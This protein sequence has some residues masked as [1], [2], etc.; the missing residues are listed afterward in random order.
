MDSL[1]SV[2]GNNDRDILNYALEHDILDLDKIQQMCM[3]SKRERAKALHPYAITP[4]P[5]PGDRWSTHYVDENGKRTALRAQTEDKLLDKLAA[6]YLAHEN[7]DNKTFHDLFEEWI[8]Y[9]EQVTAS[10]N[11]I[12]RHKQHYNKY[13]LTS[14]L[15]NT[16]VPKISELLLETECNRIVKEFSL[17]NKEWVNVKTILNG[18]YEY[19]RRMKYIPENPMQNIRITVKFRQIIKKTGRTQT[20]NTEELADLTR[21]LDKQYSETD[22]VAFMAIRLNFMM[23]L[24]VGELVAL[25]WDDIEGRQLHIVREEVRD[26]TN[27]TVSVA[28]HTKTNTDRYVYLIP[29]AL[30][31]LEHLPREGEYL[32][33]RNGGRLT[34]RKINYVLEKYAERNGL[35]TKSS[36]KM[37][38]TYAS[39]CNANGVPID[40]I[41]EQLGHSSLSTTYG[42]IYNP[43]TEEESYNALTRALSTNP[44]LKEQDAD[45]VV[46]FVSKLHNQNLSPKCRQMS[47]K[48][49]AK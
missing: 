29:E 13:L 3:A 12:V 22:D 27:N 34:S 25:K 16:K 17:S 38:K 40:F 14:K 21:Y 39:M 30:D 8:L 9:K 36:H 35:K 23:G 32:F 33:M 43:L 5:K 26:Q 20:Y 47:P 18:M 37:R 7:I 2:T 15:D 42:Y 44:D 41:R 19:A 6:L 24:R 45:N 1:H 31:I 46:D 49:R 10:P 28:E 48:F 11:T 4:P